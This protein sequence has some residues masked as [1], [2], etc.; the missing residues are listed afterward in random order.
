MDFLYHQQWVVRLPMLLLTQEDKNN[1]LHE[2]VRHLFRQQIFFCN[3]TLLIK[4]D[5]VTFN[6]SYVQITGLN[7]IFTH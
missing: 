2:W 1:C 4:G 6:T 7:L 5:N 3:D